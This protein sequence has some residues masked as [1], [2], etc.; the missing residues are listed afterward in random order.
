[1]GTLTRA[2]AEF[3]PRITARRA[4][5]DRG[6]GTSTAIAIDTLRR[7]K[8]SSPATYRNW[9]IHGELVRAAFDTKLGQLAR[10]SD[11][12]MW[13]I[14]PFDNEGRKPDKGIVNRINEILTQPNP[15]ET[16]LSSFLTSVGEDVLTLD[17]GSFE[18]E[19]TLRGE[20]VY[21]WPADGAAIA[22]DKLWN[23]DPRMPRYYWTPQPTQA[24]PLYNFDLGYVKM[25]DRS[26]SPLGIS[27][28]E[29][30]KITIEAELQGSVYNA[31]QINQAAPDGIMDLGE[32]ARPDQIEAF[33][34]LWNNL[35]A[36]KSMMAFW[37][38]TKSAKFI[39]FKNQKDMQFI[40]W[41]MYCVRKICAV[42]QISPQDMGFTFDINKSTGEVQQEQ[43]D[44]RGTYPFLGK[45]QDVIT[46]QLCWDPSF[47]GRDNNIAFRFRDVTVRQSLAK[48]ETH[49]LTLAGMP[50]QSIN[51]A[52]RDLGLPPLGEADDES[53]PFNQLMANTP[54]GL[55]LL[56]KIPSAYDVTG[57]AKDERAAE[58]A[59]QQAKIAAQN[60]PEPAPAQKDIG[61]EQLEIMAAIQSQHDQTVAALAQLSTRPSEVKIDPGA[62]QVDIKNAPPAVSV[63]NSV[64]DFPK[65]IV[66]QIRKAT[67]YH[68]REDGLIIGKTEIE[69]DDSDPTYRRVTHTKF[70]TDEAGNVLGK[71]EVEDGAE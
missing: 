9:A 11:P 36:G 22:I 35:I 14:V 46:T 52:R 27:P 43:T 21:L 2:I 30:L 29:T 60:R 33:K 50:S 59:T 49:K 20:I 56:D 68:H 42:L 62:I 67:E 15:G 1:M 24:T 8:P 23:G 17:A 69:T 71:E 7:V 57:K 54:L 61:L 53:N 6:P 66:R 26:Y 31:R 38:G 51:E 40:E 47:G 13:D 70:L 45:I 55:V 4:T 32:N 10:A 64:P 48:A 3:T 25:H 58:L 19:R 34:A 41:Q 39:P 37:G 65:P 44:E 12:S 5:I 63:A 28:L 16:G 18:I